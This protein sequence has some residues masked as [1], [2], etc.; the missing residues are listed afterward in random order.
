MRTTWLLL[1]VWSALA[2]TALATQDVVKDPEGNTVAVIVDCNSCKQIEDGKSCD[3]GVEQGFNGEAA[4]GQ[5]LLP[6]NFRDGIQSHYDLHMFGYLKDEKGEPIV[7]KYVRIFLPNTWTIRTK[8][9]DGGLF[10]LRLGATL[11]RKSDKPIVVNLG[12]RRMR[13][14]SKAEQY[15][16]YMLRGDYKSCPAEAAAAK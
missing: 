14:D 8:T 9:V 15:A 16:L 1:F 10:I 4:C 11:E 3:S 5:C 12:D 7:D 13:R 6:A 2:G